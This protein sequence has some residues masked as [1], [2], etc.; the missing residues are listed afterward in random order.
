MRGKYL[1]VLVSFF[2]IIV[3]SCSCSTPKNYTT[4]YYFQHEQVL[5]NIETTYSAINKKTPFNIA[6]N[7]K[8]FTILTL[9]IKTDSLTYRYEFGT[10][11][12]RLTDTLEKYHLDAVAIKQLIAKM[13][14]IRCIWI[15]NLDYYVDDNK[16]SLVFISIKTA[17]SA[18]L[19]GYKKYYILSYFSQPQYFDEQGRL[20]LKRR[21]KIIHKINGDIFTRINDKICYTVSAQY[22]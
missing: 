7:N 15:N 9:E 3:F 21:R 20:L 5:N 6:F 13:Q 16:K 11:E 18:S 19:F 4:R 14:S 10:T 8:A 17:T 2:G 12:Q 1:M 22:R